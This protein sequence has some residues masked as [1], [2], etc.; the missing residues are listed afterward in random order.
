MVTFFLLG[1]AVI[2]C[3]PLSVFAGN[4]RSNLQQMD[5]VW[6]AENGSGHDVFFSTSQG[7]KWTAPMRISNDNSDNLHPCIDMAADGT[8]W[9]V[10]TAV[11]Q[12]GFEIGYV[13][14]QHERWTDPQIV[15]SDLSM[16]I[17]PTIVI[18]EADVPWVVWA[19]NDSVSMDEI[20]FTRFING[21]WQIPQLVNSKNNV[22][23]VLP[24]ID[25]NVHGRCRVIWDGYR[26]GR[27][28]K[29][30]VIWTGI[31]WS[32]EEIIDL[33][34]ADSTVATDRQIEFPESVKDSTMRYL[35]VYPIR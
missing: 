1:F 4:G 23:D 18:D 12:N 15:P 24:V 17:A 31:A 5:I 22:P 35:R 3:I 21:E 13:V 6:A 34:S 20:Y 14:N 2:I 29:L 7:E 8:K 27:Y 32:D 26:N 11:K 19:G 25:I 30:K 10:W 9:M 16:N 33:D 28:V